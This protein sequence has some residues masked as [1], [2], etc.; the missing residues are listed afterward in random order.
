MLNSGEDIEIW[1]WIFQ[2]NVKTC[3]QM[4]LGEH[5]AGDYVI[6]KSHNVK[7]GV[8]ELTVGILLV[9]GLGI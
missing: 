7:P 3:G 8:Y 5:I 2:M 4:D 9:D 6:F 1:A